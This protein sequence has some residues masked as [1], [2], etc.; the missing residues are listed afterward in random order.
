MKSALSKVLGLSR[1]L[2][3][4][5]SADHSSAMHNVAL[6][7]IRR[8][9]LGTWSSKCSFRYACTLSGSSFDRPTSCPTSWPRSQIRGAKSRATVQLKELPIPSIEL[10]K[11]LL[12]DGDV[13]LVYPTV[14]QQAKNNMQKYKNCVLLTRVGSFYEVEATLQKIVLYR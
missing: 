5:I 4:S 7:T 3:R 11:D 1:R 12:E 9:L 13:G 14:V 10:N 2:S 8:R 6:F